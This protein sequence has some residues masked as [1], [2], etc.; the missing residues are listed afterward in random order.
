MRPLLPLVLASLA[1]GCAPSLQGVEYVEPRRPTDAPAAAEPSDPK[2][3]PSQALAD[4]LGQPRFIAYD[5]PPVLQNGRQVASALR[6]LYPPK[7]KEAGI[8][9]VTRVWV[10]VDEYGVVD[11]ARVHTPSG[12]TDLDFTAVRLARIMRFAPATLRGEPQAVWTSIPV[13]FTV[14]R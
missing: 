1:W 5:Q 13:T 8:G 11:E 6:Q 2:V 14:G 4:S 7:L 3:Q 9:G 10:W 12:Y